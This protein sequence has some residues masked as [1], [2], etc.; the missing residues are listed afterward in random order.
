M[1]KYIAIAVVIVLAL[2][3]FFNGKSTYNSLVTLDQEVEQSWA[4]VEVQ[5]QR[6]FDLIP[7]LRATVMGYAKHES[8]TYENVTRARA[9]LTTAYDNARSLEGTSPEAGAEFE[10]YN[11]AQSDLN[12]AFNV[13][14]N[15][16][17]EAY[18]DL[19]ADQQFLNLQAQLEGTENRIATERG[20][21]TEAVTAYNLRV[22]RFPANIWAS[23]FGFDAKQQ[24]KADTEAAKAPK[25][26]FNEL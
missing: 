13:Y 2:T 20:R 15:A 25:I 18:P 6:R 10:R 8:R 22:K 5:Y 12:R 11:Q 23:I 26:D 16:V 1:K 21:Y 7:N 3:L 14:V 24:F 19:K 4:I 17:R 9:G